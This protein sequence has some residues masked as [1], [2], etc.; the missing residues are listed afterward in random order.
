MHEKDRNRFLDELLDAA[1]TRHRSAEARSGLEERVLARLRTKARPTTGVTW[2]WLPVLVT[3]AALVLAVGAFYA[4]RRSAPPEVT[5]TTAAR[6]VEEPRVAAP[7][8]REER[9]R[10]IR[11]TRPA[12]PRP[13]QLQLVQVATVV[14]SPRRPQFPSPAPLSE[15]ERLLLRYVTESSKEVLLASLAKRGR[16]E[17]TR[18]E[19]LQIPALV[20][21]ALPSAGE[22]QGE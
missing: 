5:P 8:I 14:A 7:A 20:I 11:P 4:V 2:R 12:V 15:Q 17:D 13:K 16:L 21:H 18:F 6:P 9:A 1:L 22:G 3:A 19:E 10:A